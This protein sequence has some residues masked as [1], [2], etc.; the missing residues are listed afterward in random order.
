MNN[1]LP[2]HLSECQKDYNFASSDSE[3]GSCPIMV[4]DELIDGL[5]PELG[6]CSSDRNNSSIQFSPNL[7]MR[8]LGA[9]SSPQSQAAKS[10]RHRLAVTMYK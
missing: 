10:D 5:C 7:D 2:C 8:Q 4:M 9:H 3:K 1:G 6:A